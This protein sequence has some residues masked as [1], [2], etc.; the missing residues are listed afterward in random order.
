VR[1]RARLHPLPTISAVVAA[2]FATLAIG[3]AAPWVLGSAGAASRVTTT[4]HVGAPT[5][6]SDLAGSLSQLGQ[7]TADDAL[8]MRTSYFEPPTVADP[9]TPGSTLLSGADQ[10]D[11]FILTAGGTD[12]LFTSQIRSTAN[13]PVRPLLSSGQW[14]PV[15]DALAFMPAWAQSGDTWAPD[16]HQFGSHYVLYFTAALAGVYPGVECIGDAYSTKPT[17]PY[18]PASEPFICQR[19][20]GGDIDART[21]TAPN[22]TVY[23]L[24]KSDNNSDTARYGNTNIYSQPLSA[25]GMRLIGLPFRIFGPDEPWQGT[26]VEA[27]DLVLV[28]GVYYLFYSGNWFNSASYAIGVATCAGPLGPCRDT[29]ATP[30]LASNAQGA[31]PGEES[32]FVDAQGIWL[33][34]T[35]FCFTL[36]L[37]GGAP[38]PV[39]ITR[40]GFGPRGPYLATVG[41]FASSH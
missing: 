13:V 7:A 25:D 41:N 33:L 27:P 37:N 3:A 28:R 11:P 8:G 18:L 20:E 24:W 1:A 32:V 26:I 36:P 4:H 34:Y 40:L 15:V 21:F 9:A 17:G 30:L 16:V 29:S 2:L 10:P 19:N 23:M 38:R 31:G 6:V 12:Y 39:S 22:G 35:P 5:P 14:G